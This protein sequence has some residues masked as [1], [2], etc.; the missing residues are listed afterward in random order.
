L[1]QH[2]RL[3]LLDARGH[4][5]SEKPHDSAAYEARLFTDDII[6]VLDNLQVPKAHFWGYSMGG[7]IGFATA[8]YAP[9]RFFSFIIG[10]AHP[11]QENREAFVPWLQELQ[12]GPAAIAPLWEV[13]LSSALQARLM[14][15]DI[16]ALV[17]YL[18]QRMESDRGVQ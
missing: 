11:Y 6:A 15:N 18:R 5:G 17:A 4:G 13:P 8:K 7:R 9:E 12:K 2:Y 14:A 3:I 10:G 16:A 1:R